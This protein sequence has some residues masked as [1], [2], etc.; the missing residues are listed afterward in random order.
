MTAQ[1]IALCLGQVPFGHGGAEILTESLAAQLRRRGHE[2]A[3][4]AIPFRW[5]PSSEIVKGY[6]AW[7]LV[8]LHEANGLKID[9]LIALKFPGFVAD[10]PHKVT[11]LIQQY[12]QAYDL[13]GSEHS[14]LTTSEQDIEIRRAIHRMDTQTIGESVATFTISD[15]VGRRLRRYNG[16]DSETLYPPPSQ[17]GRYRHARY[18]DYVLSLCRLDRLK[19]V[20]RLIEALALTQGD[21]RCIIAG[22]G[23]EMENLQRLAAKRGLADRI[24]FAGFVSDEKA[25][26]LYANAR[27]L[28]YAPLDEDYGLATVEA[29][30][31][32]KPVLTTDDSGGV[33]EFVQHDVTGAIAT[34][35]DLAATAPADRR[36]AR[37]RRPRPALGTGRTRVGRRHHLGAHHRPIDRGLRCPSSPS[38]RA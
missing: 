35:D 13:F 4:I 22:R 8:D 24:T 26:E 33:L 19:R 11:W 34:L 27:A 37:R 21:A 9:R 1:R 29:M 16:L 7:R 17:E 3:I 12:R 18:G 36:V 6:L 20:D 28:Y 5:Y 31:S 38:H 32:Q 23:P 15:N 2:V 25:I 30:K 10:H 14:D